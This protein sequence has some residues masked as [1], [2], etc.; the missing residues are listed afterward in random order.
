MDSRNETRTLSPTPENEGQRLDQYLSS[1]GIWPSRSF[2]QK[3][4]TAGGALSR[5]K[6]LRANHRVS[7]GEEITVN[8]VAPEPLS[9]QPEAIPLAIFY[10]DADLIVVNKPRGMVVHPAA[11]N[12]RG[13]LV[14]ALLEHCSDLSGI[15]GKI[16]PGIVHRL[17][18]DTSGLLVVAKNDFAHLNLAAQIEARRIKR[19]YRALV[20]GHPPAEGRI[21]APIGRHPTERKKMAV[22]PGGK[23]AIT[24]FKVLEYLDPYSDVELRLESGRTHQ[25][26]VHMSHLGYPLIGDTVYGRKKDPAPITGQA[27]HAALLGFNHPRTGTYMEFQADLPE[28]M[29]QVLNWCKE[30][31]KSKG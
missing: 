3:V 8:W 11:G 14:N 9:V 17:D 27:L 16:R 19:I 7:F 10:E 6:A 26:R 13:T 4:I 21:E 31:V 2:V 23:K 29:V 28:T 30:R 18:K 1:T 5:G 25:I 22:V 20:H 15:G 12:F 24:H